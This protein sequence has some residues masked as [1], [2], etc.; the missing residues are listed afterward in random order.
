VDSDIAATTYGR[1]LFI[2]DSHQRLHSCSVTGSLH[3]GDHSVEFCSELGELIAPFDCIFKH[4]EMLSRDHV[5]LGDTSPGYEY[6][7]VKRR[8]QKLVNI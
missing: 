2:R 5:N 4:T 1:Q 7:T 3:V 6:I 8:L